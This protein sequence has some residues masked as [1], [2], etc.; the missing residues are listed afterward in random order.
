MLDLQKERRG[1]E[2]RVGGEEE[3]LESV[4][5]K[6]E[7]CFMVALGGWAVATDPSK[8]GA[9]RHVS[10]T[11]QEKVITKKYVYSP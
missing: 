11:C 5:Q 7:F 9:R 3:K 2:E 1:P 4:W 8:A 10:Q 6:K